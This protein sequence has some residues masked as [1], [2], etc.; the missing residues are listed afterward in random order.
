MGGEGIEQTQTVELFGQSGVNLDRDLAAL[1]RVWPALPAATRAAIMATI[2]AATD[3]TANEG[4]A[5]AR[6][7]DDTKPRRRSTSIHETYDL[8]TFKLL[9]GL[10]DWAIRQARRTGLTVKKVGVRK[11]IRGIDW[12]EYLGRLESD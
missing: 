1:I 5:M 6:K 12:H 10:N 2:Q 11:Y 4:Q 7:P 9:T 3:S 8:P